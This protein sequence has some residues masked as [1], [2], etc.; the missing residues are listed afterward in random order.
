MDR[1]ANTIMSRLRFSSVILSLA[2]LLVCCMQA[3]PSIAESIPESDELSV[4]QSATTEGKKHNLPYG[5]FYLD[6]QPLWEA[7]FKAPIA[8][9]S[10][11][12]RLLNVGSLFTKRIAS[13]DTVS[14]IPIWSTSLSTPL[15][16]PPLYSDNTLIAAAKD[17]SINCLDII[18]G[19][20]I[21]W[22]L[23]FPYDRLIQEN[24]KKL[25]ESAQESSEHLTAS[26]AIAK[27]KEKAEERQFR[28]QLLRLKFN[29]LPRLSYG[30]PC[31]GEDKI[32]CLSGDGVITQFNTDGTNA[33]WS[34]LE[35]NGL[36][37][38]PFVS[39]PAL[40]F[41][42]NKN[43]EYCYAIS[44]NGRLWSVNLN[45]PRT[46]SSQQ[47]GSERLEFRHPLRIIKNFLYITASNGEIF[48]YALGADSEREHFFKPK[49]VWHYANSKYGHEQTNYQGT[50]INMPSF[51]LHKPRC[52][53]VN[54]NN[55]I[56]LSSLSGQLL[57]SYHN[58]R[59]LSTPALYWN[60][61]I[62]AAT[63]AQTLIVLDSE[64]GR[65]KQEYALPFKPSCP[66]V[67]DDR[68]LYIGGD[69]GQIA[70]FEIGSAPI[71]SSEIP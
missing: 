16:S 42:N 60:G 59:S 9:L 12:N 22:I 26:Q 27:A 43:S 13:Y 39:S 46:Q 14:G 29:T 68:Y 62:L 1:N 49:F 6:A 54:D 40:Q 63:E 30:S 65:L 71:V 25:Q 47:I 44:L 37:N 69:R 66:L 31:Q 11:N 15:S 58:I 67:I 32:I 2:T 36:S 3:R 17:G 8:W 10:V 34:L 41:F 56:S 4:S 53:F 52:F 35:C 20:I 24:K 38:K 57:W 28:N 64:S 21:Y 33:Q 7:D 61:N 45:N 5:R 70:C 55:I 19:E 48:C 50:L 51:D 23:P 18:S